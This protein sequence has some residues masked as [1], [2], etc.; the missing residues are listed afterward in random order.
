MESPEVIE[1]VLNFDKMLN[2]LLTYF[3]KYEG[4]N[5]FGLLPFRSTEDEKEDD[6]IVLFELPDS[7]K[8]NID[9][10]LQKVL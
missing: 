4:R 1:E 7:K 9:V 8:I 5:N 6:E 10:E 3:A 2:P